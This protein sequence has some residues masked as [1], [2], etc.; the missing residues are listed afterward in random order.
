MNRGLSPKERVELDN[1]KAENARLDQIVREQADALMEL[2]ELI[3]GG[4]DNG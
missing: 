3:E 1:L 2:A 4:V